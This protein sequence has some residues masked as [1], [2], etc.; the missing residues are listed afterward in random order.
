MIIYSGSLG[1][2]D[3]LVRDNK[4]ADTIRN[5]FLSHGFRHDDDGGE[6]RAWQNSLTAMDNVLFDPDISRDCSVT[7]EYRIPLTTKRVDFMI[8]GL[9][10]N[11]KPNVV[12]VELKQWEK[13]EATEYE[14][15]VRT[16][17]GGSEKN[18]VHPS[19]QAY[20]YAMTIEN[21]NET[22]E[23][24]HISF[25]P[26]AFLHNYK[27][28]YRNQIDNPEYRNAVDCAP[29]FLADDYARLREF[30]K[31]YVRKGDRD[32]T[33][34]AIDGGKIKPSRLLEESLTG[35]FKGKKEFVLL[36]E[37]KKAD[38]RIREI[39][40]R[41][42]RTG[43]KYTIVVKGGPGT[44]KSVLA[45][46]LLK[47]ITSSYHLKACYATS[48]SAPREVYFS[49]LRGDNF[50]AQWIKTL[51]RNTG[52]FYE[53]NA[54]DFDCVLV[55]EAHRLQ[56]KSG[57]FHNKGEDQ[58]K[59]IINATRVSVFFID[60]HQR[61]LVRDK[62]SIGRIERYAKE[63]G[64]TL[65]EGP[66]F[67]LTSQFRCNGSDGYL[68]FIDNLLQIGQTANPDLEGLGFD[69]EVFDDPVQMREALRAKNGENK[70]RLVAG[71]CYEWK[72]KNMPNGDVFDIELPKG[73]KA[74]WNFSN[75]KTWAID[76]DSFDQVGCIHTCQGLEFD[77][78]GVIIGRDLRY[79]NGKVV[80]DQSKIAKSDRTSGIRTCKDKV[81][82]D[83]LIRNTYRVLLTRGLK[84]CFVYCEDKALGDYIKSRIGKANSL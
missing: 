4:I 51:F 49:E 2:F 12:I 10:A 81:L 41:A 54:N 32:K 57:I 80:T 5:A 39:V 35:L 16:Y 84:G 63:L 15:L 14:D 61:V 50:K 83:Q 45:L 33:L 42:A 6:Y 3:G 52:S 56:E 67:T 55:D 74:K 25:W 31:K 27:E 19:Y 58:T 48:N 23:N 11:G 13:A 65:I 44:G 24:E 79:E 46:D 8:T 38:S 64:S 68:S 62:G 43:E 82:A 28:K 66:D 53:S 47:D 29:L 40:Q 73:F 22:V 7:V 76:R 17:V 37:Q 72:S 9:D 34:Y 26:C 30:V 69:F 70:A 1:E 21:F 77:Y 20:S 36:D 60:E 59:E 71:Y 18:E 78:V 75:S